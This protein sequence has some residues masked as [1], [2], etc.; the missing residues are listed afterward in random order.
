MGDPSSE[1]FT[2]QSSP[3]DI[4]ARNE[5]CVCS[6]IDIGIIRRK[7]VTL[8]E[9]RRGL[10]VSLAEAQTARSDER[11][12]GRAIFAAKVTRATCEVILKVFSDWNDSITPINK[13]YEITTAKIDG[14]LT[15]KL[16]KDIV[17]STVEDKYGKG[18]KFAAELIESQADLVKDALEKK[19]DTSRAI[20]FAIDHQLMSYEAIANSSR[21]LSRC[22]RRPSRR[23]ELTLRGFPKPHEISGWANLV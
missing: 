10:E 19:L 7:L 4:Q 8:R 21:G 17:M 20:E 22:P 6:G 15:K 11:F 23:A 3:A 12:W 9:L 5:I 1:L 18:G 14:K 13:V 16:A 2:E